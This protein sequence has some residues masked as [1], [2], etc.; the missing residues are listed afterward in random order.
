VA[1]RRG[2]DRLVGVRGDLAGGRPVQL[3]VDPDDPAER[4][5]RVGLERVATPTGSV[6]LTIATVGEV[7]S[8]AIR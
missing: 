8:R 3:A 2:D 4:R 5:D 6:C 1:V 7:K